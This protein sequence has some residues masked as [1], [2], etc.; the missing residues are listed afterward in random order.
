MS[1]DKPKAAGLYN[2]DAAIDWSKDVKKVEAD[3]PKPEQ[4]QLT[5][6]IEYE[7]YLKIQKAVL[8][9]MVGL[10]KNKR[11]QAKSAT[12]SEYVRQLIDADLKNRGL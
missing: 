4:R 2:Q 1:N 11:G 7:Q 3:K 12:V 8:P 5:V 9:T 10:V 6:V